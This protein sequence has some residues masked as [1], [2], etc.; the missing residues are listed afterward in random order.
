MHKEI[1]QYLRPGKKKNASYFTETNM[2]MHAY[3]IIIHVHKFFKM[4]I[5]LMYC[6]YECNSIEYPEIKDLLN[7][8]KFL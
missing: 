3:I 2:Y 8:E 7:N 5:K 6:S 1:L 4:N